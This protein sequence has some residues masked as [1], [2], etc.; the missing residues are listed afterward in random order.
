MDQSGAHCERIFARTLQLT[1]WNRA[2]FNELKRKSKNAVMADIY[3]AE[4]LLRLFGMIEFI[5]W[6]FIAYRLTMLTAYTVKLPDLLEKVEIEE[7]ARDSIQE[8]LERLLM[9]VHT[10]LSATRQRMT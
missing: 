1:R 10:Y 3:G 2:Q 4:H 7:E 6:C 5:G 9:Y 8:K